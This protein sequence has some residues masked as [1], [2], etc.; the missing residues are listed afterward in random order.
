MEHSLK[1]LMK[2]RKVTQAKLAGLLGLSPNYIS[3][4]IRGVR[5]PSLALSR[6]MVD[7]GQGELDM[8]DLRPEL[9]PDYPGSDNGKPPAHA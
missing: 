6:K 2:K 3:D 8:A 5:L 1:N 9:R 7:W 4:I